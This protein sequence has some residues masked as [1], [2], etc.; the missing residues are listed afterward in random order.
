MEENAP[1][2]ALTWEVLLLIWS[3][4][5]LFPSST[6]FE[7]SSTTLSSPEI[8]ERHLFQLSK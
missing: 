8:V 3:V 7:F 1:R 5:Y 6:H 2:M 4:A